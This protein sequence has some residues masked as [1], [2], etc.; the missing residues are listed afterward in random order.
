MRNL[1]VIGKLKI[2]SGFKCLEPWNFTSWEIAIVVLIT[3]LAVGVTIFVRDEPAFI[4][5]SVLDSSAVSPCQT[6]I[7]T[8]VPVCRWAYGVGLGVS[9]VFHFLLTSPDL[10]RGSGRQQKSKIHQNEAE[11]LNLKSCH[12]YFSLHWQWCWIYQ[13]LLKASFLR[14]Y[15]VSLNTQLNTNTLGLWFAWEV[16]FMQN[17]VVVFQTSPRVAKFGSYVQTEI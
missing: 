2:H 13:Q 11:F 8:C 14:I 7:P 15:T 12:L 4:V 10:A 1:R 9:N 16:W 6:F 3:S 5:C 17:N